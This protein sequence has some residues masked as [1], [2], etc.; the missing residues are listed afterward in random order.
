MFY[1]PATQRAIALF[2]GLLLLTPLPSFCTD[3]T[4]V[5][6]STSYGNIDVLLYS[7]ESPHNVANFLA[8]VDSGA[9]ANS[10][11]HRSVPGF[12]IQGGG[13]DVV[14][15]TLTPIP[16]NAPVMGD[17]T[18]ST[19]PSNVRGTLAL[20]LSNGPNSGTNQWFF[21]EVDNSAAL[22]GTADGGPFTVFG[23]VANATSLSTMD[24]LSEIPV[25]NPS[26]FSSP[27][28]QIPLIDY[29]SGSS[30]QLSNLV[31]VN[32]ITRL[33]VQNFSSWQT[34][35]FTP[36]QQANP[37]FVAPTAVPFN[38]GTPNLMKY[39][40]DINPSVP[41]GAADRAK[42][43]KFSTLTQGTTK[44]L[45]LT[46]QQNSKLVGVN[47]TLQT[48]PDMKTW[49]TVR[50]PSFSQNGSDSTTGDPIIQAYVT[51][52]GTAQFLRLNVAQP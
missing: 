6:F 10:V 30:V 11:F 9:Y 47:L 38:D 44:F 33:T 17:H 36:T 8:Y 14:N 23:V 50:S 1:P 13:Y 26:P 20:A 29:T 24:L 41:M 21:N 43:P 45:L 34:A 22:D 35:E 37:A 52:T 27:F 19:K 40:C 46:Y 16:A 28:D 18:D 48:S 5:R 3:N 4:Y 49:T 39:L 12:I 15:S 7:D 32:S 2:A 51:A 25:P 42:L 31:F